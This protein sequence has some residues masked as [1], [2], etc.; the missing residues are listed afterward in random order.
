MT[1]GWT[2]PTALVQRRCENGVRRRR[3]SAR[4]TAPAPVM[5]RVCGPSMRTDSANTAGPKPNLSCRWCPRGPQ[6]R[7]RM[8]L[9]G[10]SSPAA[11][12]AAR[13]G[14]RDDGASARPTP[15]SPGSRSIRR[16]PASAAGGTS[17]SRPA[18]PL[19]ARD[20]GRSSCPRRRCGPP[21]GLLVLVERGGD[22]EAGGGREDLA[23]V[24][25]DGGAELQSVVRRHAT[26]VSV[27]SASRR[28]PCASSISPIPT[29]RRV[30]D[31]RDL[32]SVDPP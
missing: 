29:T 12:S 10:P 26:T 9:V 18:V 1:P 25:V 15:V 22:P 6:R 2:R 17:P 30:D 4:V 21:I 7:Y 13:A 28:F 11:G 23:P 3:R 5:R 20:R 31:F 27:V 19:A 16:A 32:N 14:F 8:T 24:P